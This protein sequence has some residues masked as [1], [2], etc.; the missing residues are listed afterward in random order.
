MPRAL[1]ALTAF[2]APLLCACSETTG[3]STA[4]VRTTSQSPT[5]I[6]SSA[7]AAGAPDPALR[8]PG[9]VG[10]EISRTVLAPGHDNH[11]CVGPP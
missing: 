7:P 1:P 10:G 3:A 4:Q 6:P 2:T 11:H 5:S 8:V 9:R